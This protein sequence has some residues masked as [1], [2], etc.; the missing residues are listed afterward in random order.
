MDQNRGGFNRGD[1]TPWLLSSRTRTP[2]H[3][4]KQSKTG[5]FGNLWVAAVWRHVAQMM[6]HD[7]PRNISCNSVYGC[8][9]LCEE[10]T[11]QLLQG[12]VRQESSLPG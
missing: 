7:S 2:P 1:Q 12:L 8:E 3:L 4:Q 6:P 9:E 5:S 11:P 10:R